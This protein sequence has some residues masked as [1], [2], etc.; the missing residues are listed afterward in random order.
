MRP[1]V[2][3]TLGTAGIAAIVASIALAVGTGLG[4]ADT[5]LVCH[6]TDGIVDADANLCRAVVI[7][8]DAAGAAAHDAHGDPPAPAGSRP[9]RQLAVP[10]R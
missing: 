10:C 1:I 2:R 5:R 7:A 8:V 6:V 9:G 4:A 3:K